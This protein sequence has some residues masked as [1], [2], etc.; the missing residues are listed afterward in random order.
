MLKYCL[1]KG[2]FTECDLDSISRDK[3]MDI[4]PISKNN[5]DTNSL[6]EFLD[7]I[8]PNHICVKLTSRSGVI[9]LIAKNEN[10]D[11]NNDKLLSFR[12]IIS[13]NFSDI[14]ISVRDGIHYM[15]KDKINSIY[16]I[17]FDPFSL[18]E[19]HISY[20]GNNT[21]WNDQFP[22]KKFDQF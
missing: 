21:I 8:T 3:W 10:L 11:P 17:C 19:S 1:K 6:I 20:F 12:I 15:A 14:T 7:A 5:F 18:K 2:N 13:A 16:Y 9:K 4:V 22:F